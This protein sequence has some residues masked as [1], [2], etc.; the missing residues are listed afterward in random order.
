M[1]VFILGV[2][3][4]ELYNFAQRLIPWARDK[5]GRYNLRF[6]RIVECKGSTGNLSCCPM[7]NSVIQM[8]RDMY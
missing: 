5:N 1:Y 6:V 7:G 2:I 3:Q 4:A 8:L